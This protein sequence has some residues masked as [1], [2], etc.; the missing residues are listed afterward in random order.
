[1]LFRSALSLNRGRRESRVPIAPMGPVQGRKH[2]GRTTGVTGAIRLSLRDGLRL[3]SCS[4]R[5]DWACLSPP[6]QD[7]IASHKRTPAARA[8]GPHDFTVRFTRVR[9]LRAPRPSHLTATPVTMRSAPRSG[10]TAVAIA[11]N[12]ISDKAKYFRAR[13]LTGFCC[14]ARR[15]VLS[16]PSH[17][18]AG[19][20][21]MAR[22]R[23]W[24]LATFA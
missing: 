6:S 10:E 3:T 19:Q 14:V 16:Q 21:P 18:P 11:S 22:A 8:S 15:V 17:G 4:P 20:R 23:R 1:L 12:R 9:R 13:G 5:R 24:S 2:G 7:A